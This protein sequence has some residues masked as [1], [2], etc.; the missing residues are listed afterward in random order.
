MRNLLFL[1]LFM[2][3]LSQPLL[4]AEAESDEVLNLRGM[5]VIGNQELPKSLM[6][7]PW[8]QSELGELLEHS[9]GSLLDSGM[10]PVDRDVFERKLNYYRVGA[11]LPLQPE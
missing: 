9:L 8:K 1:V 10:Q 6:V 11:G 5:T 2:L 7:V 3:F 4:S